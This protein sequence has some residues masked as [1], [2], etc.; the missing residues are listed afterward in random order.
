M[1]VDEHERSILEARITILEQ[2]RAALQDWYDVM[3]DTI[4]TWQIRDDARK[5]ANRERM[6]AKQAIHEAG[7]TKFVEVDGA[8]ESIIDALFN[9][10]D[11]PYVRQTIDAV[12]MAIGVYEHLLRGTGLV[13]LANAETIDIVSAVERSLRLAF[14]ARPPDDEKAV[15]DALEVILSAIGIQFTRDQDVATVGARVFKPDFVVPS[16]NLAIEVKY[17]RGKVTESQVQ[18]EL[19]ADISGYRT[20]WKRFLAVIYDCGI[21]HDPVRMRRDNMAHFGVSVLIIKH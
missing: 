8:R 1:S 9:D 20:R 6:A 18:E 7:C 3:G 2:F 4:R 5:R 16:E 21:I 12:D 13:M 11:C 19:A 14:R 10:P 17:T 15:Q